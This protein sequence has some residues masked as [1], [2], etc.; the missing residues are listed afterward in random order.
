MKTSFTI[1]S[2]S[3]EIM[4][5]YAKLIGKITEAANKKIFA[6][7]DGKLGVYVSG[8][9]SVLNFEVDIDDYSSTKPEDFVVVNYEKFITTAERLTNQDSLFVTIEDDGLKLLLRS[10]ASK[11][12]VTLSCLDTSSEEEIHDLREEYEAL[13]NDHFTTGLRTINLTDGLMDFAKV[14]GKFIKMTTKSN[15]VLVDEHTVRYA[16]ITS[17]II[18]TTDDTLLETNIPED[19]IIV[20]TFILDLVEAAGKTDRKVIYSANGQFVFF[21]SSSLDALRFIVRVPPVQFD[22]PNAEEEAAIISEP[23]D[24]VKLTFNRQKFLASLYLFDGIFDQAIWRWKPLMLRWDDENPGSVNL[25]HSDANAEAERDCEV[26]SYENTTKVHEASFQF[27]SEFYSTV[28]EF[29]QALYKD[30]K[31]DP[32]DDN[33]V[34]E[35]SPAERDDEHG[36]GVVVT[37]SDGSL[38]AIF[39]K[40]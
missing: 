2:D 34:M 15:S 31:G 35:F 37:S 30:T 16:D 26:L 10:P 17:I 36:L 13:K 18:Y 4:K 27:P 23:S 11:S 3:L 25:S 7:K 24:Q 29:G 39:S 28:L 19:K 38:R 40:L 14:S 9:Q 21:E 1:P 6:V 22:F 33:I 8:R 32:A 5:K 12:K 20:P